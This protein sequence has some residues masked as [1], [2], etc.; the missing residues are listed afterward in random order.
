[1]STFASLVIRNAVIN[2]PAESARTFWHGRVGVEHLVVGLLREQ[3][4]I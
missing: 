4:N 3:M 2:E 1:M